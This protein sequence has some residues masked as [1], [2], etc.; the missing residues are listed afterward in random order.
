MKILVPAD[1][2]PENYWIKYDHETNMDH[3]E[4]SIGKEIHGNGAP[5]LFTA[6]GK[7]SIASIKSYDYLFSDGPDVVS[8]HLAKLLRDKCPKDIQLLPAE[9]KINNQV[10]GEYFVLNILN[11]DLAF[12]MD[13]C[14]Y[15]PL[16]KSMPNGPKKFKKISLLNK[17]PTFDIF[18]AS[19]SRF[20]V[21]LSDRLA[22]DLEAESVKGV[23]F[24]SNLDGL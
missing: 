9:I 22:Q 24:V 3:M 5:V 14:T 19:E 4:F 12:D 8:A 1:N 20:N 18:R 10:V 17:L 13:N 7:V 2:Y 21:V 23:R 6:K 16:I 15:V 11:A